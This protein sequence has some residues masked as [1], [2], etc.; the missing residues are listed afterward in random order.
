ML[1]LAGGP[2]RLQ[3]TPAGIAWSDDPADPLAAPLAAIARDA[4]E[5]LV[6][7]RAAR[8]RCCGDARCGWM[9]IDPARGRGRRWCSMADCGNRAKARRHYRRR[10]PAGDAGP[11]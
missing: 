7:G 3:R 10:Q 4:A 9:F 8:V 2:A 1:A 11:P 6:S 5:L